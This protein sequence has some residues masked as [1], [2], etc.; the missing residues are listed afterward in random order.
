MNK[1]SDI[2]KSSTD[3]NLQRH[4]PSL[5]LLEL[6][7]V[8][9]EGALGIVVNLLVMVLVERKLGQSALGVY[10]YL[11]S[12]YHLTSYVAE[13]GVP[14]FVERETALHSE[15][16]QEQEKVFGDGFQAILILG[17]LVGSLCCLSAPYDST[18]TRIQEKMAAYFLMGLAIP[19]RNLNRLRTASLHGRGRHNEAAKLQGKKRIVFL[20][21]VLVLLFLGVAPSYVVASFLISELYLAMVGGGILKFPPLRSALAGLGHRRPGRSGVARLRATLREGYGLIFMD[22][23]LEV[24]LYIDLL[25]LGI[26]LSGWEVGVYAEASMLARFFLLIP[27]SIRPIF[28][29]KYCFWVAHAQERQ[30]ARLARKAAA[31]L[32]FLHALLAL[33]VLL[34][35]SEIMGGLFHAGAGE[36]LSFQVFT[37]FVPGMLFAASVIASEPL[38]EALGEMGALRKLMMTV[39]SVNFCLNVYLIPVA[40]LFGAALATMISMLLYFLLFGMHMAKSYRLEKGLYLPAGAA[41]YVS[42]GVMQHIDAGGFATIVLLVSLLSLLFYG[43]GFF[44]EAERPASQLN[45]GG[46]ADGRTQEEILPQNR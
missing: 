23:A 22:D 41:V 43:I 37:V 38:Y 15:N 21:S 9:G 14:R 42:Y 3:R 36:S 4:T 6:F 12:F 34:F 8:V 35:F 13:W 24:V 27:M 7:L 2:R 29:E 31:H 28:R 32:F 18:H 30:A 40:G 16:P 45:E 11:L 46:G 25:I 26:F 44:D 10:S 20:A 19:L 17:L 39:F 5:G 1:R 33:I